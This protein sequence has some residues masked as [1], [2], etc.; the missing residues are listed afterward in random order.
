VLLLTSDDT[1]G[2]NNLEMRFSLQGG[3]NGSRYTQIQAVDN[4]YTYCPIAFNPAGGRVGIGTTAPDGLLECMLAARSTAYNAGDSTTWADS[5]VTNPVAAVGGPIGSATGIGFNVSTYRANAT[6]MA[7]IA[8]VKT[9]NTNDGV[10]TDL[11]FITRALGLTQAERMRITAAGLVG[12][13][14]TSPGCLLDVVGGSGRFQAAG[15]FPLA[16]K[17]GNSGIPFSAVIQFFK[18]DG[19]Q[20]WQ[21]GSGAVTGTS[22]E[23]AI[24]DALAAASRVYINSSG[25]VGIGTTGPGAPLHIIAPSYLGVILAGTGTTA[26]TTEYTNSGAVTYMGVEASAGGQIMVGS[27][28][29]AT[30]INSQ[31]TGN[32]LQLGTNNTTRMTITSAGLV[33]IGTTAPALGANLHVVGSLVVQA[34]GQNIYTGLQV[35]PGSVAGSGI[36][37]G[38]IW[39]DGGNN[40]FR[41]DCLSGGVAYR[42]VCIGTGANVGIGNFTSPAPAYPLDVIGVIH[43]N[44]QVI[45]GSKASIFGSSLG[46]TAGAAN[47]DANILYYN[48]SASNWAGTGCDV[49]GNLWWRTGTSGAPN[50]G[51][52]MT[53]QQYI[54][55]GIVSPA[56]SLQLG[57]D[58]AAKPGTSTWAVVSDPRVKRNVQDLVG[59]LDVI[60]RLRAVEAEYNGADGTPEGMRVVSFLADEVQAILPHC[61][62]SHRGK[63]ADG[64]ETDVLDLNIHEILMHMLLA[65]QQ[66]AKSKN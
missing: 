55:I 11:A 44:A 28:P 51:L 1:I 50:P 23:F 20:L 17:A 52:V 34:T 40:I 13:G 56:Y 27:S 42:P 30:I 22:Q 4:G 35:N 54:G 65:I 29:Y 61:V 63:L 7:G 43:T 58:S 39:Y 26:V 38:A 59:G 24:Y 12:I 16:L 19:T 48:S 31:T 32:S 25:Y 64:E 36:T 41:L 57:L 60:T 3:A 21:V 47:T 49:N 5:I 10:S 14:T 18:T 2:T 46:P 6:V 9:G 37:V 15:Q 8:A 45:A 33:G 66:L 53:G 62:G